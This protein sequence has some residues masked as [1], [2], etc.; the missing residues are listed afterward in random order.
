MFR[1]SLDYRNTAWQCLAYNQAIWE[2]MFPNPHCPDRLFVID[3]DEF[4]KI[5]PCEFLGRC[6]TLPEILWDNPHDIALNWRLYG[7]NGETEVKEG[8]YSVLGRF[9]RCS[10]SLNLHVKVCLDLKNDHL[11]RFFTSPHCLNCH[12]HDLQGNDVYGPFNERPREFV[13]ELEIAHYA[14]KSRQECR[15]RRSFRRADTGRPR[16]EGWEAFFKEHDVNTIDE[17]TLYE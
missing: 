14:T 4:V 9:T 1:R 11:F 17:D 8:N 12:V 2:W 6:R 13:D 16:E 3:V 5:R 10:S 7:S 15:E